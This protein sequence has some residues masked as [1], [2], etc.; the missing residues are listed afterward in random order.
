[1]HN[2]KYFLAVKLRPELL[3]ICYVFFLI[4]MQP[5]IT[6]PSRISYLVLL[7][8]PY[9]H[10]WLRD[11]GVGI[12]LI[13]RMIVHLSS[14]PT[15]CV[16]FPACTF[17]NLLVLCLIRNVIINIFNILK[18]SISIFKFFI[19]FFQLILNQNNVT[20]LYLYVSSHFSVLCLLIVGIYIYV[21]FH[22]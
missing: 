22:Y 20:K 17:F 4:H 14:I 11:A 7:L 2:C 19:F 10:L 12:V 1:M 16:R 18:K 21:V 6:S 15:I 13:A 5:D 9:R 8:Q 3:N